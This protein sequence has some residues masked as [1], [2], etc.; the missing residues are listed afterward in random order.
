MVRVYNVDLLCLYLFLQVY[1]SL[2]SVMWNNSNSTFLRIYAFV[3][4]KSNNSIIN[5]SITKLN[6]KQ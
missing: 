6:L 2:K 5:I 1:Q 4:V 3:L